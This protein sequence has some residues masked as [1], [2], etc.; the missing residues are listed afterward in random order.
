MLREA[1]AHLDAC[2][3]AYADASVGYAQD[4]AKTPGRASTLPMLQAHDALMRA[5]RAIAA[6]A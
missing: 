6:L 5:A 2:A 1:L 4:D 3:R